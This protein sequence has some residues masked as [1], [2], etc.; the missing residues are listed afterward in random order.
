LNRLFK[1]FLFFSLG[2]LCLAKAYPQQDK[3]TVMHIAARKLTFLDMLK[4]TVSYQNSIGEKPLLLIYFRPDCEDCAYTARLLK[5]HADAY[6]I[7]VWLVSAAPLDQ[8]QVFES[9]TGFYEG[10]IKVLQDYT[11]SMHNWFDFQWLPFIILLDKKGKA[12]KTFESL[13]SPAAI[14]KLLQKQ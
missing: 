10:N 3:K 9:M 5:T 12:I 13:P 6:S 14:T 7:P 8:L 11:N 2:F 1:F 4:D